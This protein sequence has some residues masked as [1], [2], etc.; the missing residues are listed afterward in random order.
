MVDPSHLSA[1]GEPAWSCEIMT[2]CAAM[3][4]NND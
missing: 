4:S 1:L 3:H 2:P